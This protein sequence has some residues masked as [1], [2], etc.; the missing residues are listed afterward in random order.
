M[1]GWQCRIG[2]C[3]RS[4]GDLEAALSHQVGDHDPHECRV[5]GTVVPEGLLAIAH[6]FEEHTR[7][8]FVRHYDGDADDIRRREK[9]L[10]AVRERAD[11]DALRER[12]D[13]EPTA[14]RAD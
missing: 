8:D 12:L 9:L 14:A 3:D 4:F 5:C 10:S 2:D 13:G 1:P 6:A 7:A 11:L